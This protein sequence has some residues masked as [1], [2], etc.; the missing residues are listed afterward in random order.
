MASMDI[1]DL[2][3]SALS[4][5]LKSGRCRRTACCWSTSSVFMS[6]VALII[7]SC[8]AIDLAASV[9]FL[10]KLFSWNI[11]L[12]VNLCCWCF[13]AGWNWVLSLQS[14][15]GSPKGLSSSRFRLTNLY[16]VEGSW[17]SSSNSVAWKLN[18][19]S[20][21]W[22]FFERTVIWPPY[23]DT[24]RWHMFRPKLRPFWLDIELDFW[25]NILTSCIYTF[26]LTPTP[27]SSTLSNSIWLSRS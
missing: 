17:A 8:C 12:S 25:P 1:W 4:G 9:A 20:L 22:L 19:K 24:I 13:L 14:F 23:S 16:D 26:F 6:R 27:V 15:V 3:T 11:G 5:A 21:P 18:P 10:R 2:E 7:L